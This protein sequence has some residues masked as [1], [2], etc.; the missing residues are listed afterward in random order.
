MAFKC[1]LRLVIIKVKN[2]IAESEKS[3]ERAHTMFLAKYN[4]QY[5]QQLKEKVMG[6]GDIGGAEVIIK[7]LKLNMPP[8]QYA[9]GVWQ[10]QRQL[11]KNLP[12]VEGS[13]NNLFFYIR[14]FNSQCLLCASK[15]VIDIS[16]ISTSPND[17]KLFKLMYS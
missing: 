7:E 5:T 13:N 1:K 17:L 11:L 3:Y 8:Q 9:F 6:R 16:T 12:L 10:L 15:F 2:V 4:K 14:L